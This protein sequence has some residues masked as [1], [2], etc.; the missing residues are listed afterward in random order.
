MGFNRTNIIS[1]LLSLHLFVAPP[2]TLKFAVI[3]TLRL[4][5]SI[6]ATRPHALFLRSTEDGPQSSASLPILAPVPARPGRVFA[7]EYALQQQLLTS[8]HTS[9]KHSDDDQIGSISVTPSG[10]ATPHPDPSDKRLPGILHSYFGQVGA[11]P[12]TD[13]S[14]KAFPPLIHPAPDMEKLKKLGVAIA[15]SALPTA[16]NSP[17]EVDAGRL[18]QPSLRALNEQ[19]EASGQVARLGHNGVPCYPTPPTSSS[20]SSTRRTS[21]GSDGSYQRIDPDPVNACRPSLLRQQ[22]GNVVMP[23][24]TRDQSGGSVPS[25]KITTNSSVHAAHISNPTS[26]RSSTTPSTPTFNTPAKTA[27]SSLTTNLEQSKL[28]DG[29]RSPRTKNTPPLTPRALSNDGSESARQSPRLTDQPN[30]K[31]TSNGAR[32]ALPTPHSSPPVGPPKGKLSVIVSEARGLRPSY[33]PYA[34]TVFEW[35]ESVAR[36]SKP[37]QVGVESEGRSTEQMMDGVPIKKS[38]GDMGRSI[39][40]PMKSR[41]SSTTSLSDQKD[42]K[43]GRQVTDPRW[44]HLALL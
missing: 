41:Q 38:G 22:S 14:I 31:P 35:I 11:R 29:V 13:P 34:V 25:S 5:L 21:A 20:S 28:T 8:G 10:V 17:S 43:A 33:N 9:R 15:T 4:W 37:G 42:F 19:E 39:A 27:L 12:F 1:S 7:C 30:E 24:R 44:D 6:E 36:P 3:V 32:A 2:S 18:Q 26:P 16:P 40:I 23:L